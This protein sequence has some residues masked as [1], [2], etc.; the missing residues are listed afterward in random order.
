MSQFE[1]YF[2]LG[3]AHILDLEGFDH[4]LFVIALCAIYLGRDW[5]KI[6]ILVTAFTIGHSIT[7]A[8]A[9]LNIIKV[10]SA[11]V[12]FLIPVTI[13]ITALFNIFKPRPTNGRGVQINYFFA[14]FFGL[15]HGLGFSNYLRSLLGRE[16]SIFQP[17]LAF[18]LG[19]EVGQLAIVAIFLLIGSIFV[20]IFGNR[21][22]WTLVTSAVVLGMA[23]MMVLENR[24]W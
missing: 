3:I 19:L 20:G 22:E 1:V 7:L 14:L 24:Y 4:I 21:K 8:L 16:A 12:E 10:N 13:A 2:K 5:R 18:N 11:M 6:I 17:L 9:T 15:I 23:V